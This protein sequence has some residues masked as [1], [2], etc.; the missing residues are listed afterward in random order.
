MRGW[1]CPPLT[2]LPGVSGGRGGVE[3]LCQRTSYHRPCAIRP[4]G[5]IHLISTP[6]SL[7]CG[8]I[9]RSDRPH[10]SN[11]IRAKLLFLR[12]ASYDVPCHRSGEPP[13]RITP[14]PAFR[15]YPAG[16]PRFE[17]HAGSHS[18]RCVRNTACELGNLE[19]T[20]HVCLMFWDAFGKHEKSPTDLGREHPAGSD[21]VW[22]MRSPLGQTLSFA[23]R[24]LDLAG[25]SG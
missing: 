15:A 5:K 16:I 24:G 13:R 2:A 7:D 19:K 1:S 3:S 18:I 23:L 17:R 9:W 8:R 25:C 11:N 12:L 10:F 20:G 6:P 22:L 21:A 4:A 14:L